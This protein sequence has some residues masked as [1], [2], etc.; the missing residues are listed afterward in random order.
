MSDEEL[1]TMV[2]NSF[3]GVRADT[4]LTAIERRRR[5][6]RARRR[7]S[8]TAAVAIAAAVVAVAVVLTQRP[9]TGTRVSPGTQLA[10]W[11][12]I[13]KPPGIIEVKI[14]QLKDPAGLQRELRSD[15][16]PAFVRF[17]NQ[18]PADCLYYPLSPA[19][20]QKLFQRIFP[21]L[22]SAQIADDVALVI[23]TAAIPHGVGLWIEFTPPQTTNQGNGLSTV[24]FGAGYTLVYASG[25]CPSG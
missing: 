6:V 3:A 10:A 15:G 11:T 20:G 25:R 19:Q 23:N 4:P 21:Q 24:G 1:L 7:R 12:V 17:S 14:R 5:A 16:V 2:K 8:L 13:E 18:N 22:D 9:G